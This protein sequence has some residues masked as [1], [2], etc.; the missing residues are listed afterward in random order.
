MNI[1]MAEQ[2]DIEKLIRLRFDYFATEKWDMTSDDRDRLHLQL[3]RYYTSHLNIDFFAAFME[4]DDG[5]IVSTAFLVVFEKPANLS[6]PTGKTGLILN[7]LTYPEYRKMGYATN[8]MNL[9]IEEAKKQDLSYIE[10]S[11]SDLGKSLYKKLGFQE[12]GP[13]HF[14]GMKMLLLKS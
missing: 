7:V 3:Q 14:T 13:S 11:A 10:L 12:N 1:R 6:W 4:D 2:K 9:L 5:I 8:T